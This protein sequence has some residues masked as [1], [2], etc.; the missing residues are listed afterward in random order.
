[1]LSP[2]GK[3]QSQRYVKASKKPWNL[4][5]MKLPRQANERHCAPFLAFSLWLLVVVTR[6]L[7]FLLFF[8]LLFL[9]L[10]L[11]LSLVMLMVFGMFFLLTLELRQ[12]R[13]RRRPLASE[14]A[15][16]GFVEMTSQLGTRFGFFWGVGGL[17][18][19]KNMEPQI[20]A[21]F[22]GW[23]FQIF[24][25]STIPGEMIPIL[26]SIFSKWVGSTTN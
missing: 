5:S 17:S 9:L 23:W 25:F 10:L 3:R 16:V 21:E 4:H 24:L 26:T 11:L 14:V 8:F 19:L 2:R 20:Y 6:S 7:F 13:L 15:G 22:A 1:M 18:W 12:V